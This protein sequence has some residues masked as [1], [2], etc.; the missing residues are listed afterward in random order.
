MASKIC[1]ATKLALFE[2]NAGGPPAPTPH[3][4]ALARA[5]CAL[6]KAWA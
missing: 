3:A 4:T 6:L 2:I 1:N 5:V